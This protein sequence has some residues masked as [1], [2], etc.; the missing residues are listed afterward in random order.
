MKHV[1]GFLLRKKPGKSSKYRESKEV[2]FAKNALFSIIEHALEAAY[3][4]ELST[5]M[6]QFQLLNCN[7]ICVKII[8]EFEYVGVF[9]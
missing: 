5:I 8:D 2:D 1:N 6:W 3:V 7:A 9:F 4:D